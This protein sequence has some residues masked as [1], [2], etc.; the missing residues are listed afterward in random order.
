[1]EKKNSTIG[2][3]LLPHVPPEVSPVVL[4]RSVVGAP[5]ICGIWSLEIWKWVIQAPFPAILMVE[6]DDRN[7]LMGVCHSILMRI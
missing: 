1:M 4:L 2:A 6:Y 5:G 3:P 7:T